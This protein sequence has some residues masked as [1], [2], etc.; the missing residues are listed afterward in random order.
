MRFVLNKDNKTTIII[1][2]QVQTDIEEFKHTAA[3]MADSA[4]SD[5]QYFGEEIFRFSFSHEDNTTDEQTAIQTN[6]YL[7][8]R[9]VPETWRRY[10][11]P[12]GLEITILFPENKKHA[13]LEY[14]DGLMTKLGLREYH[15]GNEFLKTNEK[16]EI[17]KETIVE[18]LEQIDEW[19][20]KNYEKMSEIEHA[21]NNALKDKTF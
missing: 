19:Y 7:P 8:T 21:I 5:E 10:F 20:F 14:L 13:A 9:Y 3:Q 17:K 1:P 2:A 6:V 18:E 11:G 15:P 4:E 12:K 16:E